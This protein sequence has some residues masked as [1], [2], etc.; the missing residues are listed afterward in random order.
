MKTAKLIAVFLFLFGTLNAIAQ[1]ADENLKDFL[2]KASAQTKGPA[3]IPMVTDPAQLP[4]LFSA[5]SLAKANNDITGQAAI[6]EQLGQYYFKRDADKSI[7]YLKKAYTF[8][9]K[10]DNKKRAALCLQNTSFAFEEQKN[11]IPEAIKCTKLAIQYQI[12]LKDTL[13]QAN[14]YKYMGF[15]EGKTH[16]FPSA[17]K[18]ESIAIEL[19]TRKKFMRGVAVCYRDLATVYEEEHKP[20]SCIANI[21]LAENIWNGYHDTVR[22]F[23]ANNILLR[24]YISSNKL[25]DAEIAFQKNESMINSDAMQYMPRTYSEL[26]DY[27]KICQTYFDKKKDD[28]MVKKYLAKYNNLKDNLKRDGYHLD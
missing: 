12:E 4:M 22:L 21:I 23:D 17:K 10:V 28:K 8:Y 14:M 2:A 11:D 3:C 5:D 1:T 15:L 20:D 16:N 24:V 13:S 26:L 9:I 6:N 19:F 25:T 18:N 27:Y 7:G